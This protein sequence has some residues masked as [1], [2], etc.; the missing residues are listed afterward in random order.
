M[1]R[2]MLGSLLE[3]S[4][5]STKPMKMIAEQENNFW[6]DCEKRYSF[7]KLLKDTFK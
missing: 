1:T 3:L 5:E 6:K 2:K 7:I 4:R